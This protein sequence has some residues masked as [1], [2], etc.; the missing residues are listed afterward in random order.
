MHMIMLNHLIIIRTVPD[1]SH[2]P[3]FRRLREVHPLVRDHKRARLTPVGITSRSV[4]F[5]LHINHPW[6]VP[7][8]SHFARGPHLRRSGWEREG[9]CQKKEAKGKREG[10]KRKF[11]K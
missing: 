7:P 11:R 10:R 3:H 2:Y 5:P 8:Y 4:L 6:V 1:K 9:T